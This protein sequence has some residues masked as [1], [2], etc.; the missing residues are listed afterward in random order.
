M[1]GWMHKNEVVLCDEFPERNLSKQV[2][3]LN[4]INTSERAEAMNL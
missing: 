4:A 1:D 3:P 2:V